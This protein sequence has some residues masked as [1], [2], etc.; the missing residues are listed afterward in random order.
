MPLPKMG[1]AARILCKITSLLPILSL[2]PKALLM[3]IILMLLLLLFLQITLILEPSPWELALGLSLEMLQ[4]FGQQVQALTSP[5]IGE[6]L[7][8]L[9]IQVLKVQGQYQVEVVVEP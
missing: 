4:P 1:Q 2:L 6:I 7:F 3:L 8:F 5:L 9:I